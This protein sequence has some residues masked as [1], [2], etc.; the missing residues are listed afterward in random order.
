MK[1]KPIL[2][3]FHRPSG[4]I[5]G[6][7][8]LP[9]ID[10][11]ARSSPLHGRVPDAESYRQENHDHAQ[12]CDRAVLWNSLV[13]IHL[14]ENI[15]AERIDATG[16][17]NHRWDI[18]RSK[19]NC[20]NI[21]ASGNDPRERQWQCDLTNCLPKV[22]WFIRAASSKATFI[23]RNTIAVMMKITGDKL[24]PSTI[25]MPTILTILIGG[26]TDQGRTSAP[27]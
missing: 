27:D 14:V 12:H 13:G 2:T 21:N 7:Y 16:E 26:S 15:S 1:T 5:D 23:V 25:P 11:V 6:R 4:R 18:K 22:A 24:R 17:A 19:P 10:S 3:P 8:D 9:V 20:E